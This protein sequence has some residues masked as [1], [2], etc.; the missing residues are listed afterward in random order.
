MISEL[1]EHEPWT[2]AIMWVR[3]PVTYTSRLITKI[4]LFY[5]LT[6]LTSEAHSRNMNIVHFSQTTKKSPRSITE[7]VCTPKCGKHFRTVPLL[8]MHKLLAWFPRVSVSVTL[9]WIFLPPK[10]TDNWGTHNKMFTIY[11]T[12]NKHF[13][14][15]PGIEHHSV[16]KL[17]KFASLC[18]HYHCLLSPY[19]RHDQL[20]I[21]T[22]LDFWD[23]PSAHFRPVSA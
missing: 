22:I 13:P 16:T 9:T 2:T 20:Y 12:N 14:R 10:Y 11:H 17:N 15:G 3:F 18:V 19:S 8:I 23:C 21:K 4:V 1:L 5:T 6:F 7:L